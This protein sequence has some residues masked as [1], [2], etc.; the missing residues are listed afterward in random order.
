MNENNVLDFNIFMMCEK[1]NNDAL[2]DI[3]KGYHIR[4]CRK[5]ELDIWYEFPFDN[6]NDKKNM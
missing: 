1:I 3:P 4:T 6:E 2:T 5:D